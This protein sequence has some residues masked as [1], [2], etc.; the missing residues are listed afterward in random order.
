MPHLIKVLS[1][2]DKVYDKN[3]VVAEVSPQINDKNLSIGS[4][5]EN[6]K[7]SSIHGDPQ[8]TKKKL[9]KN[10]RKQKRLAQSTVDVIRK[11][12]V[13]N[14]IPSKPYEC[15]FY[16]PKLNFSSL[17]QLRIWIARYDSSINV[18]KIADKYVFANT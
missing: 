5:E 7:R 15:A 17:F 1:D 13:H 18:C 12:N 6:E 14:L 2:R 16:W 11:H 4:D 3:L 10:Q 9:N 8:K